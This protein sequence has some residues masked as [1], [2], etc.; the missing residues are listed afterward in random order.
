MS[1]TDLPS[2]IEEVNNAADGSKHDD[3][4]TRRFMNDPKFKKLA[5]FL[6]GIVMQKDV[7][8]EDFDDACVMA[9]RLVVGACVGCQHWEKMRD[10]DSPSQV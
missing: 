3:A 7:S 8:R 2:L 4:L 9:K 1:T 5:S 10:F 6:C